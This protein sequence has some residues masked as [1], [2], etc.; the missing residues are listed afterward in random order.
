[1]PPGA[2]SI[3]AFAGIAYRAE[4]ALAGEAREAPA[5]DDDAR[6]LLRRLLST[7]P[8]YAPTPL[9]RPLPSNC[10]GNRVP[11]RFEDGERP[12]PLKRKSPLRLHFLSHKQFARGFGK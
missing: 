2:A 9:R 8:I 4:S 7:Q 5:R 10:T 1:M 6:A 11:A 3:R 12:E